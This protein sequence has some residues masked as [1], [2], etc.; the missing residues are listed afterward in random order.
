MLSRVLASTRGPLLVQRCA[1]STKKKV[2]LRPVPLKPSDY[3]E[4]LH[5]TLN[6]FIYT[7]PFER[8]LNTTPEAAHDFWASECKSG[9]ES[10]ISIKLVDEHG[11]FAGA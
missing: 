11:L 1:A 10:G 4:M 9:C 5:W 6:S 8:M 7:E 3:P 2:V